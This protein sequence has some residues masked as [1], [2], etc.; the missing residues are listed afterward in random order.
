MALTQAEKKVISREGFVTTRALQRQRY[1]RPDGLIV[2]SLPSNVTFTITDKEGR[3]TGGVRDRNLDKWSLTPPETPLP[4]CPHCLEWHNTDE[5]VS[6]CGERKAASESKWMKE[7]MKMQS[8][9]EVES[10]KV[11]IDELKDMMKAILEKLN[12]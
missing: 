8:G 9:E 3:N 4:S 2:Y 5:D 10:L 1:Y 11:E 7:A 6:A 12:G